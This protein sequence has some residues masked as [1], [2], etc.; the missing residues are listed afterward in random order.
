MSATISPP[1]DRQRK[2]EYGKVAEFVS[3]FQ[4]KLA[5]RVKLHADTSSKMVLCISLTRLASFGW[6]RLT[7]RRLAVLLFASIQMAVNRR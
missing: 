6:K 3:R 1:L 2:E 5:S 7:N 4:P